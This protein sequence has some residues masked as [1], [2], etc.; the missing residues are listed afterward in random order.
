MCSNWINFRVKGTS[1][2]RALHCWDRSL[3]ESNHVNGSHWSHAPKRSR[4]PPTRG[5]PFHLM[6]GC[7][8]P[9]CNPTC[10]AIYDEAT[11]QEVSAAQ[12]LRYLG[13]DVQRT[14]RQQGMDARTLLEML[15][16]G[17]GGGG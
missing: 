13:L 7:S 1:L 16:G 3:Q 8:W 14:A 9:Q 12:V 5:C 15:S 2:P 10:P 11:G 6:D 4:A 17:G